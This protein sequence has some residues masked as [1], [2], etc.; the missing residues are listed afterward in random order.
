VTPDPALEPGSNGVIAWS[1]PVVSN[2]LVYFID[3]RN[4][5]YIVRYTGAHASQVSHV[6]FLE[7]NSNLGDAYR[8]EY[9][10]SDRATLASESVGAA[11]VPSVPAPDGGAVGLPM[12]GGS[13]GAAVAGTAGAAALAVGTVMVRRRRRR[14]KL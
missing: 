10:D 5:L 6:K 12:T 11:S 3:I 4:G 7:G 13:A 9:G 8:L 14:A 1:Y 2:G